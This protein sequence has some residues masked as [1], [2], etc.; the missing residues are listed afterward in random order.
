MPLIIQVDAFTSQPFAGNPAAVCI[1]PTVKDSQWM[2][3]VAQEM[4][5]SETAFLVKQADGFDLRWFTPTTEVDLCGH[6]TL[7]SAH[8]LWSEGHLK[9]DVEARFQT[10][11]GLLTANFQEQS[12]GENWI[13][14]NFPAIPT[15]AVPVPANLSTAL[16]VPV[17]QVYE[18]SVGLVIEVDSE[19]TVR[20][21]QPNFE[22]LKTIPCQ[23][24]IVT[25]RADFQFDFVSRYFAPSFG[26]DEDPVTG[27]AHCC[28]ATFWHDRLQ[29]TEFLAYQASA[30]GGVVKV[31][32]EGDRVFLGGQA[33]TVLR[34]ELMV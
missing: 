18:G 13:E 30:R 31:R 4:N 9:P 24:V 27:S 23:G 7:A 10:R 8:V 22:L 28:L 29:K 34:G 12:S 5:L 26:I 11:S 16:G 1:L 20:N 33:I 6:A 14:L 17:R 15:V 3:N 21:I 19:R 25:S 32:Y 2:Q